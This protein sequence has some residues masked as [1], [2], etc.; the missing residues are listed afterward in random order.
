MVLTAGIAACFLGVSYVSESVPNTRPVGYALAFLIATA[1]I[2]LYQYVV[3][4]WYAQF[5]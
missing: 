4:T 1:T 3:T 5:E 2:Y